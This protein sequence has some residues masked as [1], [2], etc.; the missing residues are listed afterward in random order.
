MRPAPPRR[1][2]EE[3]ASW[4]SPPMFLGG[5]IEHFAA[6]RTYPPLVG[7]SKNPKDFSGRRSVS[8]PS[9]SRN[10]RYA[11]FDPPTRGGCASLH[12]LHQPHIERHG[13]SEI[14][15]G[16]TLVGAMDAA[17]IVD[18]EVERIEAEHLVGD[19]QI[20][21]RI[22]G[23]GGGVGCHRNVAEGI[24]DLADEELSVRA[25]QIGDLRR[26]GLR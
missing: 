24:L 17:E 10:L 2:Q 7:A 9:P 8:R 12:V 19:R 13:R 18:A 5:R 22:G 25:V 23:A 16:K 11:N 26:L 14:A 15:D 20:V 3:A 1:P 6:R 21:A 4:K